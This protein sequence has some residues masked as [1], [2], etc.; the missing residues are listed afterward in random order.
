MSEQPIGFDPHQADQL[1][2]AIDQIIASGASSASGDTQLDS[3]VA[4][5]ALLQHDLP[6]DLPDPA[7]RSRL[8][9]ELIDRPVRISP[10]P[11]PHPWFSRNLRVYGSVAA[12]LVLALVAGM[13][14]FWPDRQESPS[15]AIGVKS[16][17]TA[18][19]LTQQPAGGATETGPVV[20]ANQTA[21]AETATIAVFSSTETPVPGGSETTPQPTKPAGPERATAFL[22][23]LP[24]VNATTVEQGPAPA[25][26]GGG[27]GPTGG[28]TYVMNATAT[29]LAASAIVYH[30]SPPSEDPVTFCREVARK[31]GIPADDVRATDLSGRVEVLAG[32]P[33]AS[34]LYWRPA[35]GVFQL[36]SN[37]APGGGV[38]S[39]TLLGDSARSWL[40]DIGYPVS[41]LGESSVA[42]RD[43]LWQVAFPLAGVPV[44]DLGY[45]LGVT[46]MLQ[47]DGTVAEA[48]GYWLTIDYEE[49]VDLRS[50]TDAWQMVTHGDGYWRDG[51]LSAGG[52]EF[53]AESV[54]LGA[55]LTDAGKDLV[56]QPV[57]EF[58]GVFT[59]SDGT[60]APIKVYAQAAAE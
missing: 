17:E 57:I 15:V 1:D 28:V 46:V 58:A 42:E 4:L 53:R 13:V 52:G 20:A 7:F 41:A 51:G 27:P 34:V 60:T 23:I 55:I 3:L 31:A 54:H 12:I 8:K 47:R 50:V 5:A 2:Q 38:L 29:A 19:A 59:A 35:A 40:A 16:V 24:G 25:S 44:P 11:K 33:G 36:S 6:R 45:P 43:G 10:V 48:Y 39:P 14:A 37:T 56:L 26:E 21:D 32:V 18:S 30:L 22:A 9:A 49:S